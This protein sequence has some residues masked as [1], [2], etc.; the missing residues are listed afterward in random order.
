MTTSL[1]SRSTPGALVCWLPILGWLPGY[2][3]AWLAG[4]I[5][6][7]LS[8]WALMLSQ[9]LG[10][11][12]IGGVPVQYGLYAAAISGLHNRLRELTMDVAPPVKVVIL[13]LEGT[14]IID[15]QGSDELQEAAKE[16]QGMQIDLYLARAKTEI[17]RMLAHYGALATIP[18]HHFF[19][20]VDFAVAAALGESRE[21]PTGASM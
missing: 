11:A 2:N 16:L 14:D 15:L 6:A 20:G 10:Y 5:V 7:G 8:V 3:R 21:G 13:D 12:T 1:S 18:A 17:K 4:D 9:A 19:D